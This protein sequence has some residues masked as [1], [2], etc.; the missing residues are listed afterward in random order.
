MTDQPAIE[1]APGQHKPGYQPGQPA[2]SQPPHEQVA[3]KAKQPGVDRGAPGH[4]MCCIQPK[5]RQVQRVE[6]GCLRVGQKGRAHEDVGIPQRYVAA[7]QDGRGVV[8]VRVKVEKDIARGQHAV[9]EKDARKE[10]EHEARQQQCCDQV[11]AARVTLTH[12]AGVARAEVKG[13][14]SV[15]AD[16]PSGR[17]THQAHSA[18]ACAP[19]TME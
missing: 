4:L 12:C 6:H 5:Q 10:D 16:V 8:A 3:A 1:A 18:S 9:G 2:T 15:Q 7:A 19:S 13:T 17:L 11:V 14:T